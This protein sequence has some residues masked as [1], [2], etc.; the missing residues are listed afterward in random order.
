[1]NVNMFQAGDNVLRADQEEWAVEPRHVEELPLPADFFWGTATAAYQI[2]GGA[3]QDG[4]GKS[5][6]DT[7]SHLEPS[8]T[9]DENGDVACDH[10]TRMLEDLDLMASYDVDV[11]RFSIAWSRVIPLGGRNDPINENGIAFYGRLIDGLLARNIEPIVTLYHWDVPQELYDRYGAFLN[12]AEFKADF[13]SFARLCFSRFGDRVKKWCTF[14]EPYIIS[15]F[16]HHS[17][18]LAPGHSAAAGHDS[19]IEPWRV[20]HTIILSHAAVVDMYAT[21][22]QPSQNGVIS[23]VLNG[24]FYEPWDAASEEHKAAAQRRLEFYIG[25]FGDPIFLGKNYPAQMR[26]QMGSRLP[27]FTTEEMTLL[28]KTAP[29]NAY[30][31][32]N[33]YSTKFARALPGPPT[34]DDCTGNVEELATNSEGKSLGPVSGMAWL[35]VAPDGF[36]KLMNWVWDRY[37][38]PIIITENGCPCPGESQMTLNEAV[39]DTFRIRYFGLYLDAI[40]RAIHEDGVVVQGYCAWSLM[41]NFEWS[42]GY[43]PRYGITHVN[44]ETLRRTPKKS[45]SYLEKSFKARRRGQY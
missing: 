39:N 10:Y 17:G 9:N 26:A 27:E 44:Y 20:G 23:I 36:R 37:H 29:S 35:R 13:E 30:Y 5:I 24:H 41:D 4:K 1:M 3:A 25:W 22:F 43:G 16:G 6:W 2:E 34:E 19:R 8:R 38:L 40:S 21:E 32:M 28:R 42:A 33:H 14:N 7:F 11:Y 12:T 18:V 45:A 15:I 31:G